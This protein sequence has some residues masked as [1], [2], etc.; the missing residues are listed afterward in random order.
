MYWIESLPGNVSSTQG[1]YK[2]LHGYEIEVL[3]FLVM[4]GIEPLPGGKT[5]AQARQGKVSEGNTSQGHRWPTVSGWCLA[6]AVASRLDDR[7]VARPSLLVF[8]NH[9]M[10]V[11]VHFG[12][13]LVA[14]EAGSISRPK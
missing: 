11:K 4:Y 8:P 5:A 13:Y 14:R 7:I 1:S 3:D 12:G 6:E 10:A 2:P 9:A